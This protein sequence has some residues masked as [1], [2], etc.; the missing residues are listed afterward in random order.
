MGFGSTLKTVERIE[1]YLKDEKGWHLRGVCGV[2]F[3]GDGVSEYAGFS[4]SEYLGLNP[5]QVYLAIAQEGACCLDIHPSGS[6]SGVQLFPWSELTKVMAKESQGETKLRF[7]HGKTEYQYSCRALPYEQTE[8][9]NR[10][11]LASDV[12]GFCST[13]RRLAWGE[14]LL[15]RIHMRRLSSRVFAKDRGP[16]PRFKEA[17]AV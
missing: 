7:C 12:K 16:H 17:W 1:E 9:L 10:M 15:E 13:F 6:I 11:G 2:A 14:P 3:S 5:V 8:W 4:W